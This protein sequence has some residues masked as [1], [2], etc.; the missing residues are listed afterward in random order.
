MHIKKQVSEYQI[1][2]KA[3]TELHNM[4][5]HPGFQKENH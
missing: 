3:S 2:F 1:G 4:G 5:A